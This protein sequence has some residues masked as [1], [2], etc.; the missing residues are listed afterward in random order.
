MAGRLYARLLA[1]LTPAAEPAAPLDRADRW[2]AAG[3]GLIAGIFAWWG[4]HFPPLSLYGHLGF[5]VWFEADQP[6]VISVLLDRHSHFHVR[7]G[8]H[9]LFSIVIVPIATILRAMGMQG[10]TAGLAVMAGCAFACS[11]LLYLTLRRLDIDKT[12]GVLGWG[13]FVASA[14]FLHWFSVLETYAVSSFTAILAVYL[15]VRVKK[16]SA[17]ATVAASLI[18][19]SMVITNWVLGLALTA[20]HWPL[21][22]WIR[23][24]FL[25][26]LLAV[27]LSTAQRAVFPAAGQFFRLSTL[28]HEGKYA[29]GKEVEVKPVGLPWPLDTVRGILLTSAVAPTPYLSSRESIGKP[30]IAMVNNQNP[31]NPD[32]VELLALLAW[33]TMLILSAISIIRER[34]LSPSIVAIVLFIFSQLVLHSLYGDITFLYA[35]D[36]FILLLVLA[37]Q[38][39]KGPLRPAHLTATAVF[40]VAAMIN[41]VGHFQMAASLASQALPAFN[42][43][44][45]A[46][47]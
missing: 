6:R 31:E 44:I 35:G 15:M 17:L 14:T 38:G 13:A 27:V 21:S 39:A 7:D 32:F 1:W 18:S 3:L 12:G 19:M 11:A 16:P 20:T 34:R 42:G 37:C 9:P 33:A 40:I 24:T 22:R 10:L 46:L 45:I 4:T 43:P 30:S 41:N 26:L 23:Y 25:A 47:P 8:V 28:T 2:I 36:F 5:D 29:R